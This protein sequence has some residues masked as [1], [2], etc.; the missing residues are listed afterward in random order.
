MPDP[1][2]AWLLSAASPGASRLVPISPSAAYEDAATV[3]AYRFGSAADRRKALARG[4]LVH[5]LLQS[6]PDIAT[7]HRAAALNAF[8][9]RNAEAFSD[10]E[11][12]QIAAQVSVILDDARFAPLFAPGSR[13]EVPI[14]GRIARDGAP[15]AVAGQVDRL[16]VTEQAVLIADYKTDRAPPRRPDDVP[17]AYTSQLALYRAVLTQLYPDRPVRAALVWTEGPDLMEISQA[18]IDAA[19]IRMIAT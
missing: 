10:D 8:L 9:V 12:E 15:L 6:L 16:A 4:R 5:R 19:L 17:P 7:E 13:G 3:P 18:A 11:Q 1:V 14:V 2:P